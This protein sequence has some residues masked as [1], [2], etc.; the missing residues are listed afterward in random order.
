MPYWDDQGQFK[1]LLKAAGPFSVML[2]FSAV[3]IP[4]RSWDTV[5]TLPGGSRGGMG[6]CQKCFGFITTEPPASLSP[7]ICSLASQLPAPVPDVLSQAPHGSWKQKML[8]PL[9]MAKPVCVPAGK[10]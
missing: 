10:S 9:A 8:L 4:A 7:S 5:Q 2:L 3:P 6:T 1:I